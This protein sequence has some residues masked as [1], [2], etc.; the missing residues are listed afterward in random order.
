MLTNRQVFL[1][2]A[3]GHSLE[4]ETEIRK[5]HKTLVEKF[6]VSKSFTRWLE[7]CFEYKCQQEWRNRSMFVGD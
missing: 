6:Q 7:K 1:F 3:L 4:S 2:Q 5:R